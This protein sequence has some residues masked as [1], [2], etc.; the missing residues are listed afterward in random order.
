MIE[1]EKNYKS[2]YIQL[3][4]DYNAIKDDYID[5]KGN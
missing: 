1:S 2:L 3:Q 4:K 5:L